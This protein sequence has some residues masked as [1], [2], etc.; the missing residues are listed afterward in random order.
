[1]TVSKIQTGTLTLILN[2]QVKGLK[3]RWHK[4]HPYSL[5]RGTMEHC[6]IT[7]TRTGPK[8]PRRRKQIRAK[9]NSVRTREMVIMRRMVIGWKTSEYQGVVERSV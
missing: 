7:K 4:S 2:V 3:I 8:T 1:M 5:M 6:T 9:A